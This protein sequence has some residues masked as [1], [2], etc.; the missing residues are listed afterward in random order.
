MDTSLGP[1]SWDEQDVC[2]RPGPA[3]VTAF[4]YICEMNRYTSNVGHRVPSDSRLGADPCCVQGG[5]LASV[6]SGR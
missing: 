5:P 1:I 6:P 2:Y 3:F 4:T